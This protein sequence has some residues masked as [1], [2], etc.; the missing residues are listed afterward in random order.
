[1]IEPRGHLSAGVD[2]KS[3]NRKIELDE[4]VTAAMVVIAV[5]AVSHRSGMIP[6]DDR[7]I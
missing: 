2:G 5:P 3:F 4:P 7:Y 1:M 6:R